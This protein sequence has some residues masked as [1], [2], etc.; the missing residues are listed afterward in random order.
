MTSMTMFAPNQ[1]LSNF[2]VSQKSKPKFEK[3]V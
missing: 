1:N 2:V 3:F